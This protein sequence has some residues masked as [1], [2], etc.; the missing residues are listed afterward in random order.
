MV[1]QKGGTFMRAQGGEGR[2][3]LTR[4]APVPGAPVSQ[5]SGLLLVLLDQDYQANPPMCARTYNIR[6]LGIEQGLVW[7][8]GYWKIGTLVFYTPVYKS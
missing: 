4:F 8:E 3:S 6:E 5:A 2:N 1:K 7:Q